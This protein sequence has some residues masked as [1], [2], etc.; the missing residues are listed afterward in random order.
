MPIPDADALAK[1]HDA[2]Q[3]LFW[4][5][6]LMGAGIVALVVW[7]GRYVAIPLT[8]A[9]LKYFADTG[10]VLPAMQRDLTEVKRHVEKIN[11]PKQIECS[12]YQPI[13]PGSV[14]P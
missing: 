1:S 6:V 10:A 5:V 11:C 13:K 12:V 7:S 2:Y 8:Q 9:L 14:H 3:L 4:A